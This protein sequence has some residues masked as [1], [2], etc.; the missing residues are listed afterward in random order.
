MRGLGGR[1]GDGG[2]AHAGL[3]GENAAGN[4]VLNGHHDG[5]AHEPATC[6]GAGEGIAEDHGEGCGDLRGVR[7][8]HIEPAQDVDDDHQRDEGG[9]NAPNGL[10]STKEHG[11]HQDEEDRAGGRRGDAERRFHIGGHSIGLGEVADAKG[12]ANCKDGKEYG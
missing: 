5:G 2:G 7:E 10:D 4:T 8:D 1:G 11:A 9:G 6:G 12:R 3:I